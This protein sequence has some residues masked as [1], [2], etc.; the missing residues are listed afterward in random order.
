MYMRYAGGGVG[1]YQVELNDAHSSE[2]ELTDDTTADGEELP[3]TNNKELPATNNKELPSTSN[4]ELP[5]TNKEASLV[6]TNNEGSL[7]LTNNEESPAPMNNEEPPVIPTNNEKLVRTNG[8]GLAL[9][10]NQHVSDLP[11][12]TAETDEVISHSENGS[13]SGSTSDESSEGEGVAEDDLPEDGEGGFI[14]AEDEE[15]YAEL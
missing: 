3:S 5:S 10:N 6:S 12:A 9:A 2:S 11:E 8:E 13:D 14:D 7:A 1:H 4:E 15:G